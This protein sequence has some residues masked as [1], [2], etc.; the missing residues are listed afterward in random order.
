M[1]S[2]N[3]MFA[4]DE[5]VGRN[6]NGKRG[7]L[8]LDTYRLERIRE[9]VFKIYSISNILKAEIWKKCYCHRRIFKAK[10]VTIGILLD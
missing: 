4:K 5:F 3:L 10:K 6:C 1:K 7:K 9:T 2:I 8:P